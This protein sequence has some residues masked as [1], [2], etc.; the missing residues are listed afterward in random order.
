MKTKLP[1]IF[2]SALAAIAG[3]SLYFSTQSFPLFLA[4]AGIL[5]DRSI[6]IE[7]GRAVLVARAIDGDTI[8]FVNGERLRY[9][10][11]DTPEEVDQRKPVQC[12]AVEA[13]ARNKEL[14][15][16]KEVTF[17]PDV[18]TKDKYGRWLGFVYLSDGTFVNQ[19]LVQEG[20]AFAYPYSPD[21]SKKE[22]FRGLEQSARSANLGLWSHCK[23]TKLSSGREQTNAVSQ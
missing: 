20:F 21:I 1:Y 22:F 2:V 8:E 5:Y 16:G 17:Y 11:I 9:V 18:S 23:V 6:T 7:P 13:A 12:G 10:G 4:H 14:V 3:I 19:I 15:E